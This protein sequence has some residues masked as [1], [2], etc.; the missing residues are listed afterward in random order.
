M[1]KIILRLLFAGFM[2]FLAAAIFVAIC[3][4]MATHPP[5]FYARLM[6]QQFTAAEQERAE[7]KFQELVDS[8]ELWARQ[9]ARLQHDSKK[10]GDKSSTQSL[11]EMLATLS[12]PGIEE[13][14]AVKI[15]QDDINAVLS[16]RKISGDQLRDVRMQLTSDKIR[17]AG[18]LEIEKTTTLYLSVDFR[19]MIDVDGNLRMELLTGRL[20]KIPLPMGKLLKLF[21]DE[22][23]RDKSVQFD[24]EVSPVAITFKR[25]H[26]KPDMFQLREIAC[27]EGY[28]TLNLT[29]PAIAY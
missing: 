10:M 16:S 5:A 4:W 27:E 25:K 13:N 6:Q 3:F 11:L 12:Q 9:S 7:Q 22:L 24:L 17:L 23:N 2:C 29:A 26:P 1:R 15:A 19:L 20:G 8:I 21:E 18:S 14:R 28:L